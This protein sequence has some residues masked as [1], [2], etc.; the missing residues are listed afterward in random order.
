MLAKNTV[1]AL[2]HWHAVFIYLNGFTTASAN[3]LLDYE[4][5]DRTRTNGT[6]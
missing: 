2:F 1:S 5:N 4:L 3:G 6:N